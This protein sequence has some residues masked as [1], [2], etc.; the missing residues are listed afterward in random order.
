MD[1]PSAAITS[2]ESPAMRPIGISSMTG[3]ILASL[4]LAPAAGDDPAATA[5]RGWG[6]IVDPDG[7]CRFTVERDRLAIAVPGRV[8][9]LS[10][11][12]GQVNAPRVLR[13]VEGDFVAEVRVSGGFPAGAESLVPG[14][15]PFHA[16][17]L[18][19]WRDPGSYLR[20]ER[21][22]MV[23]DGRTVS[24]LNFEIRD[25]GRWLR[26]GDSAE[27]PLPADGD[28]W[29]RL[30]RR[31]GKVRASVSIDGDRWSSLKPLEVEL[32]RRVR[33]GVAATH[34]TSTPFEPR[35]EGLRILRD[36]AGELP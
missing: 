35:F 30:D 27:H 33:V 10:A 1:V 29:L 28:V 8:H 12:R 7:D 6:T 23:V 34:N 4:S 31:G 2:P 16:A 36:S 25:D 26:A 32:P 19:L 11:E 14:R 5:L 13:E 15:R 20:L 22:S 18:I 3:L 21:A 17:G 24:Y 9:A